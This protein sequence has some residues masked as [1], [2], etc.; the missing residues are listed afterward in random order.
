MR[1]IKTIY[2]AFFLF[3]LASLG[4]NAADADDDGFYES[5][6]SLLQ[7]IKRIGLL[8]PQLPATLTDRSA[9]ATHVEKALTSMLA[10][11][12]F[13]VIGP[14]SYRT[15]Y[16]RLN[17]QLGGTYDPRTGK[18]DAKRASTL[19]EHA[20]LA[21]AE[22]ERLDGIAEPSVVLTSAQFEPLSAQAWWDGVAENSEGKRHKGYGF[23]GQKANL[24]SPTASVIPAYSLALVIR[25][26]N[27]QPLYIALGGI[28]LGAYFQQK[29]AE[30]RFLFVPEQALLHDFQRLSRAV[31]VVTYNLRKSPE[32]RKAEAAA[33]QE[34]RRIT[35]RRGKEGPNMPLPPEGFLQKQDNPFKLPREEI[36]KQIR[37][38]AIM[39]LDYPFAERADEISERYAQILAAELGRAGFNIV[40]SRAAHEAWTAELTKNPGFYDPV[41]GEYDAAR[42]SAAFR[43]AMS[44]I[45]ADAILW[46]VLTTRSAQQDVG[47]AKWDGATQ[48][49]M[50]VGT[51][52]A[53]AYAKVK[54]PI[55]GT[56]SIDALSLEVT[57]RSRNGVELYHAM[58]GIQLLERLQLNLLGPVGHIPLAPSQL[59]TEPRRDNEAVHIALR[60]LVL[61]PQELDAELNPAPPKKSRR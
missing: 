1:N 49:A 41:T 25:D 5:R 15:I 46:P 38:V 17:R 39:P 54:A 61:S 58:G 44:P 13:T 42:A 50:W 24:K 31:D 11:A 6:T 23:T 9:E 59:L 4:V 48:N 52:K 7:R 57:L 60:P 14:E 27:S 53:S 12:G 22:T 3:M 34:R 33:D 28:Q 43:A 10:E 2:V 47:I 30:G 56:G 29:W 26:T 21:Y 19:K 35:G 45:A 32:Q 36:L 18:Q 51:T 40:D 37:S 16:D 20:L 55:A 8:P